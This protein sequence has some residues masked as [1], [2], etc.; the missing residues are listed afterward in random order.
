VTGP[1]RGSGA[2]KVQGTHVGVRAR[3]AR[4]RSGLTLLEI[5]VA[6][7]VLAIGLGS[8]VYALL[9]GMALQRSAAER[10]LA[11]QAAESAIESLQAVEFEEAFV[12]FNGKPSDDPPLGV[13]PGD[14]FAVPGLTAQPGDKDGLAGEILF[15]GDNDK[16]NEDVVDVELGMP[17]DLTLDDPPVIDNKNHADDYRVLPVRVRVRWRGALGDRELVLGTILNHERKEALP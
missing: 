4:G 8:S 12:R 2:L 17:R 3:R 15:P 13:S 11:L 5:A 1:E 7:A 10:T 14:S 9:G 6:V 16:L